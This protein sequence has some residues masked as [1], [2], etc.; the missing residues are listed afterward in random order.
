LQ[1][2]YDSIIIGGGVIGNSI[3]YHLSELNQGSILLLEKNY[4]LSGTSGSTQA[5]VWIHTKTPSWYGEF[6]MLSAEMYPYLARKIGDIEYSRNGGLAFFYTPKERELALKLAESQAKV[7]IEIRVLDREELRAME[8]AVSEA[9]FG[10][11]YSPLDGNINPFRLVERYMK[12]AKKNNVTYSYYNPV[13]SLVK[14]NNL[15]LVT[16]RKGIFHCKNLVIAAGVWSP[17][18]GAMLGIKIPVRPVRGQVIITEALQ[19]LLKHTFSSMRQTKNGEILIGYS[20]EDAGMDRSS[21][22]DLLQETA[23]LAV[24]IIPDL[25]KAN[26]I[27]C[28]SGIRVMPADELPILGK[29]PGV[30][31]LFIAA[32]HSGF[33][34]NPLVGTLIAELITTGEPSISL[35]PYSITRF[36]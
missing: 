24:K 33:T 9:I 27:R 31:H 10:A 4:P 13:I 2:D 23:A 18:L 26:L 11:T 32:M 1:R 14:K 30:D 16:S 36:A 22:L 20:K 12:A 7:G 29:V 34:L 3:A 28:F 35:A 8:P 19:P 25:A 15:F 6:S 21:T 5:W 17:E